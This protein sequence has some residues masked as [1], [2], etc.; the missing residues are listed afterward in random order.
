MMTIHVVMSV[1]W[2]RWV[3]IRLVG[4][5]KIRNKN[6]VN[7]MTGNTYT[8]LLNMMTLY[9]MLKNPILLNGYG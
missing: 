6:Y 7:I 9:L 8:R 1:S 3:P 4:K 2:Q 5:N